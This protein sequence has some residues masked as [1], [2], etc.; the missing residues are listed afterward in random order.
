M[1]EIYGQPK[2]YLL[3]GNTVLM[4]PYIFY[5]IIVLIQL[6]CIS[7]LQVLLS[8]T[9]DSPPDVMMR[10]IE[11]FAP[12]LLENVYNGN[13]LTRRL[14]TEE[15]DQLQKVSTKVSSQHRLEFIG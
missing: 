7:S 6:K 5:I 14:S 10:P 15:L 11:Q 4:L 9:P 3:L 13:G 12:R 2:M 8:K 1:S